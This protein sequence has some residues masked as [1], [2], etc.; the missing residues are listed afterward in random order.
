MID[1]DAYARAEALRKAAGMVDGKHY[2]QHVEAVK[3]LRRA[4]DEDAA[5][6]LLLRLIDAV[7]REA[8]VPLAGRGMLP[9]WYYE[10]LA[11]IY[12][13]HGRKADAKDL[14]LRH[15]SMSAAA[16]LAGMVELERLRSSTP[17]R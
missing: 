17:R 3:Q 5:A 10:Q 13:K 15:A 16:E 2:T 12:R 11:I 1:I 14:L 9:P 8:A 6:G 7:E 4:G